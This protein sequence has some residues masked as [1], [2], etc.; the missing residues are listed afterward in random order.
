MSSE[1]YQWNHEPKNIISMASPTCTT[2]DPKTGQMGVIII[3]II[4]MTNPKQH[5]E[6]SLNVDK[7]IEILYKILQI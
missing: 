4:I 7:F 5:Q 2:K 1:I 6:T 3:P